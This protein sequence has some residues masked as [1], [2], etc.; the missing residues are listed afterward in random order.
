[1]KRNFFQL[2]GD[3][4]VRTIGLVAF[5]TAYFAGG[6]LAGWL[7]VPPDYSGTF[8]IPSGLYMAVLA[9]AQPR[10]WPRLIFAAAAAELAVGIGLCEFAPA[11]SAIVLLGNSAEAIVGAWLL[12]RFGGRPYR[13]RGLRE[14]LIL[15]GFGALLSPML[16]ATIGVATLAAYSSVPIERT[17][18]M[19]WMGDALGVLIVAPLVL[20]LLEVGSSVAR[21]EP[22]RRAE[23]VAML[24]SLL[25]LTF[26][27]LQLHVSIKYLI[28]VPL[29]WA[30]MRFGFAGGTLALGLVAVIALRYAGQG[31]GAFAN[32]GTG[33]E[34]ELA[35]VQLFLA[36][37]GGTVLVLAALTAQRRAA[38]DALMRA[39]DELEDRVRGRTRELQESEARLRF[40]LE[41]ASVG[42]WL[43]NF[44]SGQMECSE[45]CRLNFGVSPQEPFRTYQHMQQRI[46]PDDRAVHAAAVDAAFRRGRE[47]EAEFRVV[48]RESQVR[49]ILSRGQL[50][51]AADRTPARMTGVAIDI[52]AR[53]QAQLW[54]EES[55]ARLRLA[56]DAANAG[57]WSWDSVTGTA[58]WDARFREHYGFGPNAQASFDTWIARVHRQDRERVRERLHALLSTPGDDSWNIEFRAVHPERG[59]RWMQELGRSQRDAN[60]N[61]VA[62]AGINLDITQRKT[63]EEA[64][65]RTER[66]LQALADNSPDIL[67][68]FDRTLRHVFVNA[69]IERVTGRPR[70]SF[71]GRTHREL[72]MPEK[73][74]ERWDGALRRVFDTGK[75]ESLEFQ[76]SGPNG[77]RICLARLVPEKGA[78]SN[79]E[80]VL[81]ITQDITAQRELQRE[82]EQLLDAEQAARR[83]LERVARA[84]DEFLATLSHEL[85]TPLNAIVGWAEVLRRHIDDP[86]M[87]AEGV[88]VIARNAHVQT[89]LIAD[90][91][92]M[93]RILSGKL[94]MHVEMLDVNRPAAAAAQ[95][96]RSAAEAKG[97]TLSVQLAHTLPSIRGDAARLQQVIWNLLS[98]AIKFTPA[99]GTVTLS[100]AA[101]GREISI[102][103]RDTGQG[104]EADF[105]P[106]LFERFSQADGSAAKRHGGLG[107]G[108]A[109]VKQL[110]ELHGGS[111]SVSSE[112]KNRGS[113]FWVS[114]P[115]SEAIGMPQAGDRR[116]TA[117]PARENIGADLA[118]TQILVV[119]DQPDALE[120]CRR[121]LTEA[122]AD[123]ITAAS[124]REAL[125]WLQRQCPNVVVS[126]IGMPE[127]DGHRFMREVRERLSLP[128]DRLPAIAV[129]AFSRP[130]DRDRALAAGYQM[131]VAKPV[132]PHVLVGAVATV[133]HGVT[134][135]F[136]SSEARPGA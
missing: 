82:R 21:F 89:R 129:T 111:V 98:N 123:V 95:T 50:L 105:L 3:W 93:N 14:V 70:E 115:V 96:M 10:Q 58:V 13:L 101:H 125:Q 103:V 104:I 15:I 30:A 88:E 51:Q 130:E 76:Y 43:I 6:A 46:H 16:S 85:R 110:V 62:L 77:P 23:A 31:L 121:V 107:L 25:A 100:T 72:G 65:R 49:W 60:G 22:R 24:V 113:A 48:S 120:L 18:P 80:F 61:I 132:P 42:T 116:R 53:K 71:I 27:S 47:Y 45:Q 87:L 133:L 19:W 67:A 40:V 106:H 57:A 118:G 56:M 99:G 112:G 11:Q 36:I 119:D 54:L 136:S 109:I 35:F 68:R 90:L 64:L 8:W 28:V 74:C 84:K 41:T 37:M 124:G 135:R 128:P 102:V 78:E 117:R 5:A 7:S 55:E 17:W 63:A 75:P 59:R 79:V 44:G 4:P 66:E 34:Q 122:G 29:L 81:G 126:D 97:V 83:E 38:Q 131:H 127:V 92:D 9:W 52:T 12:Q 39:R 69:A 20:S 114:L 2:E 91:L 32:T 73:L 33:V 134:R 26:V 86:R 94:Q 108:L 1:V